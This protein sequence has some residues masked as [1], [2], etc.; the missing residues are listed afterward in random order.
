MKPITLVTAYFPVPEN[1][2]FEKYEQWLRNLFSKIETPI[3]VYTTTETQELISKMRGDL[4]IHFITKY[5][6]WDF[7]PLKRY[8][9]NFQTKQIQLDP[10]ASKNTPQS[11]AIWNAK[12]FML[13]QIS[14][15][16]PFESDYFF[17]IDAGSFR[18]NDHSFEKWPDQKL[19]YSLLSNTPDRLLLATINSIQPLSNWQTPYEALYSPTIIEG[20]FF[21]GSRCAVDWL[22]DEY[23][24][25]LRWLDSED[26]FIGNDQ[27]MMNIILAKHWSRC[28]VI[29]ASDLPKECKTN[30]FYF[31]HWLSIPEEKIPNCKITP[32]IHPA[33]YD[34]IIGSSNPHCTF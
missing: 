1:P 34:W 19:I 30:W 9:E 11:Y 10:D 20:G 23:Y 18:E 8:T 3:V 12:T 26:K 24:F 29:D 6:I 4:P 7:P 14:Q 5:D 28:V 31:Q 13:H 21:G 2:K 16:N 22:N 32:L 15:Q 17:W 27:V 25:A 33:Q